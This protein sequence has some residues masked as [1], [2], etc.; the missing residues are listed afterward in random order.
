[1]CQG[2]TEPLNFL[3][4]EHAKGCWISWIIITLASNGCSL[5]QGMLNK[6]RAFWSISFYAASDGFVDRIKTLQQKFAPHPDQATAVVQ[7]FRLLQH[8]S[9]PTLHV[10]NRYKCYMQSEALSTAVEAL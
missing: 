4:A 8:S 5:F 2:V 6:A 10:Q 3:P 9:C 1:M 7:P